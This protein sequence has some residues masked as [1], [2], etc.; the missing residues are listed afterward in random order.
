MTFPT[1]VGCIILAAGLSSRMGSPKALLPWGEQTT[2]IEHVIHIA[3]A[4]DLTDIV[5]IT[6]HAAQ[7]ISP[8]VE[9]SRAR[10]VF[11]NDY[12]KGEILSS[13]KVGLQALP[14]ACEAA[15]VMLSDQPLIQPQTIRALIAA[16]HDSHPPAVTPIFDGARGH[17][18]LF[19][20]SLW[21]EILALPNGV[22]PRAVLQN[23]LAAVRQIAVQDSGILIDI[24]TPED[25]HRLH[26]YL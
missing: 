12:A 6:G 16:W 5:V 23:H 3:Q 13:L 11:N 24:D 10:A 8:L 4:A 25:Y 26:N 18:I 22:M 20:K 19:S 21:P 17:P 2:L 7:T 15:L 9:R 1:E 14:N